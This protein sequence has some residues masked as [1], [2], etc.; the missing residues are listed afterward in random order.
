MLLWVYEV[1]WFD[2]DM[3]G[4][5]ASIRLKNVK[6]EM[7]NQQN[8]YKWNKW[9]RCSTILLYQHMKLISTDSLS[10]LLALDQ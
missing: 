2:P 7:A 4:Y 9:K 3:K 6:Q 1:K 10:L 5:R 8:N